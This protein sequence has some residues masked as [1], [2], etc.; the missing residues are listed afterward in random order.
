M[1]KKREFHRFTIF[2][3]NNSLVD[4]LK[5]AVAQD[6]S[7]K[8]EES[9]SSSDSDGPD[10]PKRHLDL[11]MFTESQQVPEMAH[12]E[13]EMAEVEEEAV[14]STESQDPTKIVRRGTKSRSGLFG[15]KSAVIYNERR[16]SSKAFPTTIPYNTNPVVIPA[17]LRTNST[18]AE[19][20]MKGASGPADSDEPQEVSR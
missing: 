18:I 9:N 17:H 6:T 10:A 2:E 7:N 19:T 4:S 8:K 15:V 14:K 11:Q 13:T 3:K 1:T 16:N 20:V 5:Q 12:E